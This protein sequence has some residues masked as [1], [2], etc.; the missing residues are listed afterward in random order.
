YVLLQL[1]HRRDAHHLGGHWQAEAEAITLSDSDAGFSRQSSFGNAPSESLHPNDSHILFQADRYDF[2]L[3]AAIMRVHYVNG[4]L[5]RV[6]GEWLGQHF[7]V[8]TRVLVARETN[9]ADLACL[10]RFQRRLNASFFE[11][12]I[13]V[14]VVNQFVKLPQVEVI[15]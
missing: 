13:G 6:P 4:H 1:L 2:L 15:R 12:P 5:R 3:E 11:D 14:I 9:E 7:E 10:L 8:D